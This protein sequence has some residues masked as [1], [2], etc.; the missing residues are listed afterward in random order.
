MLR[1]AAGRARERACSPSRR[2]VESQ[3][4][5]ARATPSIWPL[6][7]WLL[8]GVRQP[9]RIRSPAQ[10]DFHPGL[11]ISA[12][13]GMPVH[14]TA[15]GTVES[16]A[17]QRQL[18]QRRRDRARLR[19]QHALRPPLALRRAAG[20]EGQARRRH[21]LRRRDRPRDRAPHLHYEILLNGQPINPLRLLARPS[22]R[23]RRVA[24]RRARSALT[25]SCR[26]RRSLESME[27]PSPATRPSRV[28]SRPTCGSLA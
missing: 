16:A 17:L 12:D 1:D 8:V 3:Q 13:Q 27:S 21:R 24:R 15:D 6:A 18:R 14:A 20:P 11:D 2:S 7:G 25:R 19:H 10:P 9:R 23:R 28:A 4:A 26:S 22:A 5:L